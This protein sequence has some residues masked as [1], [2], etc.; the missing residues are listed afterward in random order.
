MNRLY[1]F[2][3]VPFSTLV[4]SIRTPILS[5]NYSEITIFG[6]SIYAIKNTVFRDFFG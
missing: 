1:N 6:H 2:P 5:G 4:L 3:I